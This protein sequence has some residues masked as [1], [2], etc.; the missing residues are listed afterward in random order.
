M[1]IWSNL[2][3]PAQGEKAPVQGPR[4]YHHTN[5]MKPRFQPRK[6]TLKR[7]GKLVRTSTTYYV[8]IYCEYL[9]K[10]GG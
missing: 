10:K 5:V 2:C 7:Q 9:H 4:N 1:A 6:S 8:N 3:V